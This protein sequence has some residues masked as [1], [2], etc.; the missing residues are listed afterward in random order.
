MSWGCSNIPLYDMSW[1]DIMLVLKEILTSLEKQRVL[2]QMV[3]TGNNY[4]LSATRANRQEG[5]FL[6]GI[7]LFSTR[8]QNGI[9]RVKNMN[10]KE[11][12]SYIAYYRK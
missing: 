9:W 11:N 3:D 6:L 5:K 4:Y 10:G 7:R 8:T 2:S 12:T 1:K